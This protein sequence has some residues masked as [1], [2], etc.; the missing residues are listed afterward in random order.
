MLDEDLE[1]KFE[2]Y[3][4]FAKKINLRKNVLSNFN[5]IVKNNNQIVAYGAPAKATTL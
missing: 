5:K 2:T 4:N 1:L 3:E